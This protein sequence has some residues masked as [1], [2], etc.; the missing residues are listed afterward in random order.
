MYEF[1]Y[2]NSQKS[3]FELDDYLHSAPLIKKLKEEEELAHAYSSNLEASLEEAF[4]NNLKLELQ[5]KESEVRLEEAKNMIEALKEDIELETLE[6]NNVNKRLDDLQKDKHDVDVK[7]TLAEERLAEASR[8]SFV[9]F[10][11]STAA[12]VLLAIGVNIITTTPN[13]W[14]GWLLIIFGI[15][16]G[17]LA[18][19]ISRKRT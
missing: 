17:V 3:Q 12:T 14:K 11:V 18:F 16:L 1:V 8:N 4:L 15:L 19:F 13:D 10:L 9:Q 2:T 5:K 6:L 7:L